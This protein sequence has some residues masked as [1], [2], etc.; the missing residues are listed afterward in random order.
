MVAAENGAQTR[1]VIRE[2]N[3]F[4]P[5]FWVN[6][7]EGWCGEGKKASFIK[8]DLAQW[9][10]LRQILCKAVK[11]QELVPKQVC[12]T[13]RSFCSQVESENITIYSYL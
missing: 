9:R 10:P 5:S 4:E 12:G 7:R 8:R 6:S 2:R 13:L 11:E 1:V 3:G